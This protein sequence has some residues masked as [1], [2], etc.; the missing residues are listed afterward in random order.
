MTTTILFALEVQEENKEAITYS[1]EVEWN[2]GITI[3]C[4]IWNDNQTELLFTFDFF[5]SDVKV[6]ETRT[7][8]SPTGY[9][10]E[11]DER[12]VGICHEREGFNFCSDEI[13]EYIF[14]NKDSWLK[15]EA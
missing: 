1:V 3:Q 6:P 4:T 9:S 7:V 12:E 8:F 5:F 11:P 13:E 2:D 14:E 10:F 15:Y